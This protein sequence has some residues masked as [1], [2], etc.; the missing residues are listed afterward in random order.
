MTSVTATSDG[1]WRRKL[2]VERMHAAVP[3]PAGARA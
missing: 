1:T 2:D 3:A